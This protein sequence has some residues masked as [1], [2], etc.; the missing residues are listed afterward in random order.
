MFIPTSLN[1]V[2][3]QETHLE[4]RGNNTPQE[5]NKK[6]FYNGDKRKRKFKGNGKKNASVK[7]E[8]EKLSCKNCSKDGHDE[9]QCWKRHPEMRPKNFNNKTKTKTAATTQHDLGSD[10]RDETKITAIGFQGKDS[11]SSTSY[12]SSILSETQHERKE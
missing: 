11:I 5:G 9:D 4:T 2:C 3:V 7:K 8:R 6:P 10:L 1:E 12:S